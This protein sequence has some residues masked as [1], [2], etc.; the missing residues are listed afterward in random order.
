[1]KTHNNMLF[2]FLSTL[3]SR[4]IPFWHYMPY[5]LKHLQLQQLLA[6]LRPI[7]ASLPL[8]LALETGR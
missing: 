1:M 3:N 7:D 2:H 4:Y 6:I 5:S 8:F